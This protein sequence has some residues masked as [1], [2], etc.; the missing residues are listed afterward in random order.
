MSEKKSNIKTLV[1]AIV[2]G[3]FA[4][5]TVVLSIMVISKASESSSLIQIIS[6]KNEQISGLEKD[7]EHLRILAHNYC[8][9]YIYR[10]PKKETFCMNQVDNYIENWDE[11]LDSE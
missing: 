7:K 2:A 3:V 9:M 6:S 11:L 10:D 1:L 5:S 8:Y 4:V